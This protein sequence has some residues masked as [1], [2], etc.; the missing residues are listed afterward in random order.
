MDDRIEQIDRKRRRVLRTNVV[1]AVMFFASWMTRFILRELGALPEWL[2]WVIAVPFAVSLGI[3]LFAFWGLM[4]VRKEIEADAAV[5]EALNDE[6]ARLNNLRA[7][8]TG[9]FAMMGGL[10][11]FAVFNFLSPIAD[12]FGV[13]IGL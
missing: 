1:G 10:A 12:F 5:N 11:F 4:R 2:D 13:I 9:F 3:L 7:F 6:R 8:K